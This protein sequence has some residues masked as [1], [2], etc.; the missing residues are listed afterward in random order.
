MGEDD[1]AWAA[2]E[3][4]VAAVP[5]LRIRSAAPGQRLVALNAEQVKQARL[6][7]APGAELLLATCDY[8]H[9]EDRKSARARFDKARDDPLDPNEKEFARQLHIIFAALRAT[10]GL[11]LRQGRAKASD[12][13]RLA[14]RWL[15]RDFFAPGED[16]ARTISGPGDT[17]DP[18]DLVSIAFVRHH[19]EPLDTKELWV[20]FSR[21]S[22]TPPIDP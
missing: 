10:D 2:Y 5:P 4:L 18:E 11:K 7:T 15:A 3:R 17:S 16:C 6:R 1:A 21:P 9:D 22:N 13:A 19:D 12:C 20:T 8:E 14:G